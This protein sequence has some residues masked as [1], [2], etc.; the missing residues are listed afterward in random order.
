MDSSW[1]AIFSTTF[2]P[3]AQIIKLSLENQNIPA[4]ILDNQD[5]AHVHLGEIG[6]YVKR[7]NVI[8]AKHLIN[9]WENE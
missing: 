6:V 5:S 1:V 9:Q 2:A 7:E 3:K 8:K 4:L